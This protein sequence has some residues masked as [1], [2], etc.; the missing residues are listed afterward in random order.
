MNRILIIILTVLMFSVAY[1]KEKYGYID[2]TGKEVIKPQYEIARYF[3]EGI[4]V[5]GKKIKEDGRE[6]SKYGFIDKKGI[7]S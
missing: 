1:S 4:A 3:S 5:V 7:G 2:R 6:I